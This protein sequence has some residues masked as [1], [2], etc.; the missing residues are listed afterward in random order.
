MIG[1][2]GQAIFSLRFIVQWITSEKEKKSV[3]PVVFW[4]LSIAGS[5]ILLIY[6]IERK[7]PVFIVGQSAGFL[8]YFRNL[9]LI[10]NTKTESK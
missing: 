1:F 9:V 4:Y 10:K 8:I 7:D 3:V 6:A 2:L 5:L